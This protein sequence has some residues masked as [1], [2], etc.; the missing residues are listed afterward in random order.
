MKW[1][2][3]QMRQKRKG[4][5]VRV[6]GMMESKRGRTLRSK[7]EVMASN[8][9]ES[10]KQMR[11]GKYLWSLVTQRLLVTSARAALVK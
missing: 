4:S 5:K 7:G 10:L 1:I 8:D 9:T 3:L 2:K 6:S 11:T